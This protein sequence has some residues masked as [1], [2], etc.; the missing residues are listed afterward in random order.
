MSSSTVYAAP[1]FRFQSAARSVVSA[2]S[3]AMYT[4]AAAPRPPDDHSRAS[5]SSSSTVLPLP[6]GADTTIERSEPYASSKHSD[7]MRLN[8]AKGKSA[9]DDG[10]SEETATRRR[11]AGSASVIAVDCSR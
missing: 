7:C 8:E 3:G 4:A 6:V 2:L 1:S 5:A 10:G 9:R 11:S